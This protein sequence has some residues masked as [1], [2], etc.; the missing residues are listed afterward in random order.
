R[1]TGIGTILKCITTVGRV[2]ISR[3]PCKHSLVATY[4]S[5]ILY[6]KNAKAAA[7]YKFVQKYGLFK[8]S[9]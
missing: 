6:S 2:M 9:A 3:H 8:A 5:H 7:D 1:F 4:Y